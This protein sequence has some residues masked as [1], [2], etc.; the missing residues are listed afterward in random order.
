MTR[1]TDLAAAL[2]AAA[3]T[4]LLLLL[5][6]VL[7]QPYAACCGFARPY[8]VA[9]SDNR[10]GIGVATD[11][12]VPYAYWNDG[13]AVVRA[14]LDRRGAQ[15]EL[16]SPGR[17][18]RHVDAVTA[19][20]D[21]AVLWV[22]RD[23]RSGR[24]RHVV[25]WRGEE[26]V[27]LDALQPFPLA[28]AAGP[29]GPA[30]AWARTVDGRS[31]LTLRRWDGSETVVARSERSISRVDLAFGPDGAAH[32]SWLDGLNDRGAV[33]MA[34][35]E[36]DARYASVDPGGAVAGPVEL[37]PATNRGLLDPT[38]VVVAPEGPLAMW[39]GPEGRLVAARP[40]GA[41]R[42]LGRGTPLGAADGWLVWLEGP[43]L[44][45]LPPGGLADPAV[46]P[47]NLAWSPAT[48]ELG[49][50]TA[51]DGVR[52]LAW[53]GPS[54]QG[55]FALFATSDAAPIRLGWRDRLAAR[56]G[57]SP[58]SFWEALGGQVLASLLAGV[59][60]TMA[61]TPVFWLASLLL[62]PRV[63]RRGGLLAGMV[64]ATAAV[65]LP[66]LWMLLRSPLPPEARDALIGS[67]LALVGALAAG[68]AATWAL[69]GRRD[70]DTQLRIL[71]SAWLTALVTI[72]ALAFLN[73]RAWTE[74][75]GGIL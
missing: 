49:A 57:W 6:S 36:W 48:P 18:V 29:G 53:Y 26:R 64:V 60:A 66:A 42:R 10:P 59:L 12:G 16:V 19:D 28:F 70:Q 73:F 13:E 5:G 14:R 43:S 27:V 45:G 74:T 41:S 46:E 37:G 8:E 47:R 4:L 32:L 50:T 40:E 24:T 30:I 7:A 67:P 23:L 44:R 21:A 65:L 9:R 51:A 72:A 71:T 61:L 1:R 54:V 34:F 63:R 31:T 33:G 75:F 55:G 20:G 3:L 39:T 17:G 69:L 25:R 22:R 15:P 68:A 62:A 52:Y 58:W 38:R 35:A 11:A 2:P 56:M